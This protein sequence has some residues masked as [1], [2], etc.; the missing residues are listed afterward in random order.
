MQI[1]AISTRQDPREAVLLREHHKLRAKVFSARLG[2]DVMVEDGL[3]IDRFDELQPTYILCI[4]GGDRVLA[5]ARLLPAAGSTMVRDIFPILIEGG[6][7]NAHPE[8]IESSRFCVDTGCDEGRGQGAVHE[9]TLMMFAGIIEWS[10]A[11]G[12]KEIVTVTDL[13]F[14]RILNRVGWHL[15]RLG[16]P[17]K[18]GVTTAVAGILAATEHQFS[19]LRPSGYQSDFSKSPSKAA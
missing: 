7:L 3:E 2:W 13:R 9:I 12:Y 18:I 5:C 19:R 1:I 14:E 8:M 15:E 4:A 10:L 17:R 6:T 16:Q 11:H